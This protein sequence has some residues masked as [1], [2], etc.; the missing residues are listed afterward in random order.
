MST[1]FRTAWRSV[2][3]NPRYA[4]LHIMG[5]GMA[6]ACG[7]FIYQYITFHLSF[8][9]YHRK[10]ER[11]YKLVS[12]ILLEKTA[13][14]EGA[15][16]AIYEALKTKVTGVEL[17]AFAMSNQHLTI[18]VNGRL[19]ESDGKAAFAASG[20]FKLFDYHWLAGQPEALDEPNTT[21]LTAATAARF[22]GNEDPMGKTIEVAD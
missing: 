21:I 13:Y 1:N 12:D 19:F 4:A 15:S 9:K 20:W 10:S 11:T 22:F 6:I 3:R 18:R 2:S 8:D 16:Y 17:A 14:N 7:L 5:L